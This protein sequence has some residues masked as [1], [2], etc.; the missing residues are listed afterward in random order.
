MLDEAGE[1]KRVNGA[2]AERE[3]Q[4][5]TTTVYDQIINYIIL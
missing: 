5:A 4:T 3:G 1:G 2:L